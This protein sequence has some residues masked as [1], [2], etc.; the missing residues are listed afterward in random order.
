MYRTLIACMSLIFL[1]PGC[2]TEVS[3]TTPPPRTPKT[4]ARLA[5]WIQGEFSS[6]QQAQTN[7][8]YLNIYL[9]AVRIWPEKLGARWIYVEQAQ[10]DQQAKPYRQR[11]YQVIT[12]THADLEVRIY[13][14]APSQTPPAGSYKDPS[15]F[16]RIDP[17]FL[18]PLGGCTMHFTTNTDGTFTGRIKGTGCRSTLHGADHTSSEVTVTAQEIRSWDRGWDSNGTQVWGPTTGPYIFL[19]RGS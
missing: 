15:W 16:Q 10:A 5:D 1:L 13:S 7:S 4:V 19:R 2:G 12:G 8:N 17:V 14:F 6:E 18:V 9:N 11:I 3:I